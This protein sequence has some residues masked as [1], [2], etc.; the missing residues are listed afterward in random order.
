MTGSSGRNSRFHKLN[1]VTGGLP[2][3]RNGGIEGK[4]GFI[5]IVSVLC[6]KLLVKY[7]SELIIDDFGVHPGHNGRLATSQPTIRQKQENL[8]SFQP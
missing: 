3:I 4:S 5:K 6:Q 8:E 1:D 2:G 7:L